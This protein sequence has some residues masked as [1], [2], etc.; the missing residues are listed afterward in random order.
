MRII[1]VFTLDG[2]VHCDDL[3]TEL[4]NQNIDYNEVNTDE[5]PD[6]WNLVVE[7]TK[8]EYVPVI[9]I[10]NDEEGNE[11]KIYTPIN[12]FKSLNEIIDIINVNIKGD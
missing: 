2:C 5:Y 4:L 9:M 8:Q 11:G 6:V 10:I 7:Q 1:Y 3:K 12:D